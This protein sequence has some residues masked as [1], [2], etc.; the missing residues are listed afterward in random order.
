MSRLLALAL[1]LIALPALAQQ[2][3]R[4]TQC[5]PTSVGT[6]S[7][8]VTFPASGSGPSGPSYYLMI[9]APSTGY[10]CV[11]IGGA[12]PAIAGT[13]CAAGSIFVQSEVAPFVMSAG[14]TGTPP[15][16]AVNVLASAA[17]TPM[18]C[19]YQ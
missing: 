14:G 15:P 7:T 8:A 17:A 10:L 13:G 9:Q 12:T 2:S 19:F 16:A 6:G 3:G 11:A 1:S 18:T 4:P 5:G